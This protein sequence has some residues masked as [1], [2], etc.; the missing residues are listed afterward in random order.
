M[1]VAC[2]LSISA[3]LEA[4]ACNDRA[5]AG[6][7]GAGRRSAPAVDDVSNF[8]GSCLGGRGGSCGLLFFFDVSNSLSA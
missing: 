7:V 2:V 3:A 5:V 1:V 4:L 8:F 6:R